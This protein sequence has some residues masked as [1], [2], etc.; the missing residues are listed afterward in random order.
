M[1]LMM[2]IM[3]M[4]LIVTGTVNRKNENDG[5]DILP[6]ACMRLPSPQSMLVT[7]ILLDVQKFKKKEGVGCWGDGLARH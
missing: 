5:P 4:V 3:L 6:H 2:L 1:L 7:S